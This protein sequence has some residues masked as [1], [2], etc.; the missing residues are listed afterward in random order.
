M[1]KRVTDKYT[2][3]APLLFLLVYIV[4]VVIMGMKLRYRKSPTGGT[5]NKSFKRSLFKSFARDLWKGRIVLTI[6]VLVSD[7]YF[8]NS[9]N[10]IGECLYRTLYDIENLYKILFGIGTP[11][12]YLQIIAACMFYLCKPL[13]FPSDIASIE[14]DPNLSLK[15]RYC[16]SPHGPHFQAIMNLL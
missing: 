15:M 10:L 9:W 6:L 5:L 13:I 12:F 1:R 16:K 14:V 2:V 7:H 3:F 4:F 8:L 11:I